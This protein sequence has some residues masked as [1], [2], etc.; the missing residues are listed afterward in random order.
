MR[1]FHPLVPRI[2]D[3]LRTVWQDLEGVAP[4]AIEPELAEI[5]GELEGDAMAINNELL[6][7][8]G[9]RKI[10]LETAQV[11]RNLDILHCVLFPDPRY[12]LP[13]FGADIV[14]GRGA[15]SAAIVDLSPTTG[16]LAQEVSAALG[17]RSRPQF[18]EPRDV[19]AWGSIFSPQVLFVRPTSA[20][21]EEWFLQE[22]LAFHAIFIAALKGAKPQPADHPDTL[23]RFEG[24]LN[25]CQQQRRNDKTRRVLEMAFD[26]QWADNYIQNLLFD[27][28]QHPGVDR[29]H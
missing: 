15:I 23:R 3:G 13:L 19:P 22:L 25:Y 16:A 20:E 29:G 18:K 5:R 11:G 17:A 7:C 8:P 9:L 26:P 6:C 10:H 4:L 27:D 14:A 12:D 21:E 28:P 1:E 24:Q 2:A